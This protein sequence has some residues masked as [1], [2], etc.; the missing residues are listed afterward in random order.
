VLGD[1]E[2]RDELRRQDERGGDEEDD[3]DR[4]AVVAAG[5][6]DQPLGERGGAPEREE[7]DP[8]LAVGSR[9]REG[10][11]CRGDGDADRDVE[12]RA[13]WAG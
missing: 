4:E 2:Q 7:Q 5:G 12:E 8:A 10:G 6:D 13:G 1:A 9:V 3:G 11:D